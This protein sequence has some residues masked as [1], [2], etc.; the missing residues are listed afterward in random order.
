[1]A[2]MVLQ[3]GPAPPGVSEE[4]Y[5]CAARESFAARAAAAVTVAPLVALAHAVDAAHSCDEAAALAGA[6]FVTAADIVPQESLVYVDALLTAARARTLAPEAAAGSYTE[7]SAGWSGEVRDMSIL[8][9]VLLA[10]RAD[11]GTLFALSAEEDAYVVGMTTPMARSRMP[12]SLV[13]VSTLA[14]LS[15]WPYKFLNQDATSA[16]LASALRALVHAFPQRYIASCDATRTTY[17]LAESLDMRLEGFVSASCALTRCTWRAPPC[18]TSSAS[19]GC[20][21]R[22]WALLATGASRRW[23]G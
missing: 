8:A 18:W 20:F 17:K 22:S 14:A 12:H 16:C 4:D 19:K 13:S 3:P 9:A 23:R 7:R 15:Y 6:L 10:R 11:A 1:M 21:P 5:A 2:T